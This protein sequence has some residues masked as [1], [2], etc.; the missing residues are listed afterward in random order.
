MRHLLGRNFQLSAKTSEGP[1][2]F[3]KHLTT[4]AEKGDERVDNAG[5]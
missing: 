4:T 3:G 2:H 1:E 5:R